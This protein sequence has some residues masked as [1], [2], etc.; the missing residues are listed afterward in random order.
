M[1]D[2]DSGMNLSDLVTGGGTMDVRLPD[3][4][5]VRNVPRGT[6]RAQLMERLSKL[7][8]APDRTGIMGH[9]DAGLRG[10][11]DNLTFGL[12]D[13]VAA[14]V[15]AILPLDKLTNRNITSVWETGDLGKAFR[16]NL[17][18][19]QRIAADD[20]QNRWKSRTAGQV[21]G[22]VLGPVPGRGLIADGAAN[23]AKNVVRKGIIGAG[24]ARVIA[25]A[26]K[27]AAEGAV[28]QGLH[29]IGSGDSTSVADRL[30][31]GG[32]EA[33]SGGLGSLFGAGVV[34]GGAR[35]LS[36]V[37]SPA[38]A[39]LANMGVVMT[40]GQRAGAGTL[41]NWAENMG[42]S[43]PGIGIGIRAAKARGLRQYMIGTIN[44]G[45]KPIAKALPKKIEAGRGA[46]DAAQ[47]LISDHYDD[48]LSK[49]KAPVDAVFQKALADTSA[50]ADQL[51]P[52]QAQAFN[53]I[54]Q[55]KIAPLLS[56]KT[57]LDGPD[58][59][60]VHRS[61]QKLAAGYDK[62]G[63]AGEF[64]A[65][66]L[67]AV[68]QHFLDLAARHSPE[69]TAQFLKANE[70]EANLSRVYEA[71]SKAHGEGV[72]TPQ[73][74]SAATAKKGYGTTTKNAAAGN[75]RMQDITDAGKSVLPNTFPNSNSA[76]RYIA[77][78]L[79]TGTGVGGALINP[80]VL[81]LAA[82]VAPYLPVVDALVQKLALRGQGKKTKALA[83]EVR[84]RAYIGGMFGAPAVNS[85]VQAPAQSGQ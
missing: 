39:K 29:G 6:T 81:G 33:L 9:V 44:Q 26:G 80:A 31:E 78:G 56:G 20:S 85:L 1:A 52:E 82:P 17:H 42:E 58:L 25:G 63:P 64:L 48:A 60:T 16:S 51:P 12:A 22:S 83:D 8:H 32:D 15:N 49:V 28:Q 69:G 4:R 53:Y 70:A 10:V 79:V 72:P 59:Q 55:N 77:G 71:A 45:L 41:T 54:M 14:G 21:V 84:K 40:P 74:L 27:I 76:D 62:Q 5:V 61:L 66:E 18:E 34:R 30:T 24:K 2:R 23:L 3:G 47:D 11:T 37:I 43:I 46:V 73:Q 75:A 68:R 7:Q 38:V 13:K 65:D 35:L 50:R 19:E 67:R 36:P 57:Y